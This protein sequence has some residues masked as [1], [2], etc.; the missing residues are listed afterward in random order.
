NAKR[1]AGRLRATRQYRRYCLVARRARGA[2]Q[3][4]RR[5]FITEHESAL[6]TKEKG[7]VLRRGPVPCCRTATSFHPGLRVGEGDVRVD[8]R[9]QRV[10]AAVDTN[11][12][13]P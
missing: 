5:P 12:H 7:L 8:L 9:D 10:T 11:R 6:R 2:S 3:P 1:G 13:D 4:A